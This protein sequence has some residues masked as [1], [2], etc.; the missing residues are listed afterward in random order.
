M[1]VK[2]VEPSI[3]RGWVDAGVQ[4]GQ[5][6]KGWSVSSSL[7]LPAT[8]LLPEAMFVQGIEAET[9]ELVPLWLW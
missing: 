4:H 1:Y 6:R 2:T 8:S 7:L 9:P 3:C 5:H